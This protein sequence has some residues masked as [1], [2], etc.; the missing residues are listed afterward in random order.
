MPRSAPLVAAPRP[1][2]E[3]EDESVAVSLQEPRPDVEVPEALIQDLW[4]TQRFDAEGLSTTE[5]APVQ[6]LDPGRPNPDAGPDFRNAHVRIGSMDWRGDVEIH[7]ASRGWI[8]HGHDTDPRY[9]SVV[10]HVTLQADMWTGALPREDAST[11][12]EIVLYPRLD[13]PLRELLHAF[14]TRADEDTLPCAPRWDEVPESTTRSWIAE[15]ARNRMTAKRDR[16][17][18]GDRPLAARLQERLFAGL[19]YAKND[20]PMETLARRLPPRLVRS[21]DHPRDREALHLG[22]AGLLPAPD[23]LLDA[24]RAT[25]DYAMDLRDRFRRLQVR[26]DRPVMDATQWA[27]FRLRPNNFPPLR[28]AQ[29]AAWYADGALLADAPLPTLRTA[30]TADAP[31]SALRDAL[32]ARPPAFWRTHYHLEKS[33]AEHDPSL[34]PSRRRVLI[35]NAVVP[36]LLLDAERRGDSAQADTTL[37]VLRSL[38]PPTDSV[39]RRFGALGLDAQ[40]AFEA[41]GLHQLY[42]EYCSTGGCLQ[43][44]VGQSLLGDG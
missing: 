17:A 41:Q 22:V 4:R 11:V 23:D 14:H 34:G 32:A 43:C 6:V 24:D 15:L 37:D 16:L 31:A 2:Y 7:R 44:A 38:P 3:I 19:G 20:D 28:I 30:L 26:L 1:H 8:D 35:V 13:T 42:R 18:D 9:D 29:A 27:F 39:T 36:I 5:G 21:V 25:A 10:L 12:P 40:S 33:A